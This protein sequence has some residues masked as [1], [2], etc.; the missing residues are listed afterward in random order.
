MKHRSLLWTALMAML[1]VMVLGHA[2]SPE[3]DQE[4]W[5]DDCN[6]SQRSGRTAVVLPDDPWLLWT[7]DIGPAQT[8]PV[9]AAIPPVVAVDGTVYV[10]SL[11]ALHVLDVEGTE[12]WRSQG[13]TGGYASP[14]L[15]VD[16]AIAVL[17]TYPTRGEEGEVLTYMASDGSVKW[18]MP[19]FGSRGFGNRTPAVDDAGTVYVTSMSGI[20]HAVDTTGSVVWRYQ[21]DQNV[22][23][24]APQFH[25]NRMLIL[26]VF[27]GSIGE[28]SKC[29]LHAVDTTGEL[30]W[31]VTLPEACETG[32]EGIVF[33]PPSI[34]ENGQISVVS[35]SG[36]VYAVGPTGNLLWTAN[37]GG[38]SQGRAAVDWN[39]TTYIGTTNGS[40]KAISSSG[41]LL[42]S[43]EL[44]VTPLSPPLVDGAGVV[45][46]GSRSG[47]LF[48]VDP[49]GPDIKWTLHVDGS[50]TSAPAPS[51]DGRIYVATDEG[52]L[53]AIGRNEPVTANLEVGQSI[54]AAIDSLP[55]G[56]TLR[57]ASKYFQE[58]ILIQKSIT[59]EGGILSQQDASLP[60]VSYT[61]LRAHET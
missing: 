60:A 56:S 24:G 58:N 8:T 2:A 13:A 4:V 7:A 20:L 32:W 39:G 10:S 47:Q 22:R 53:V 6:I 44:D 46:V 51:Y 41:A 11:V 15:N 42:W 33:W 59:L 16:R 26:P 23:F 18:E 54:Q 9:A 48:A 30:A 1:V 3:N 37:V 49:L 19:I 27:T 17:D 5:S 25:P 50:I 52:T 29:E 35:R 45:Y 61:H 38:E 21:V 12:T 40:L 43:L 28:R 34:S 31:T 36:K 55:S 14:V 57:L